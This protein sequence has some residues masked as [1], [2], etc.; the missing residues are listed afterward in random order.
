M[1]AFYKYL[2][3]ITVLVTACKKESPAIYASDND[4]YFSYRT[5]NIAT[6]TIQKSFGMRP[7]VTTD[8]AAVPVRLMGNLY[9][10]NRLY[11]LVLDKS[12]TTAVEGKHF[13]LP[14][15]DSFYIPANATT[16]TFKVQIMRTADLR[17]TTLRI[18]FHLVPNQFFTTSMSVYDEAAASPVSA[19]MFTVYISDVL[20][21]P[22]IWAASVDYLGAYSREKL[23][24][25]AST[26]SLGINYFFGTTVYSASQLSNYGKQFQVYLNAQRAAGKTVYEKGGAEM[27]MGP[28]AQ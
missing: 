27:K 23:E 5:T 21:E 8:S 9:A 19:K 15:A 13:V 18:V 28:L 16:D 4:I 12:Q 26:L 25:M 10:Q 11:A 6:D 14:P 3:I 17:D 24:L 7:G 22:A 20:P 2:T 1:N